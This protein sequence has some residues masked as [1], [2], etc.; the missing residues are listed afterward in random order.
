MVPAPLTAA[1]FAKGG[2][3]E[4]GLVL[5]PS[6]VGSRAGVTD[7]AAG[8]RILT[9]LLTGRARIHS[10]HKATAK[11]TDHRLARARDYV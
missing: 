10:R 1:A 5:L 2:R 7:L 9:N 11:R 6:S 8:P 4:G 3:P